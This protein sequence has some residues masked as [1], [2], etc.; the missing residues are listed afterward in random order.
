[1]EEWTQFVY[2]RVSTTFLHKTIGCFGGLLIG[3]LMVFLFRLGSPTLSSFVGCVDDNRRETIFDFCL[4]NHMFAHCPNS[5]NWLLLFGCFLIQIDYRRVWFTLSARIRYHV[6]IWD[7]FVLSIFTNLWI[8]FYETNDCCVVC[9]VP[10]KYRN[11]ISFRGH[12]L[13]AVVW[14]W[15]EK[16]CLKQNELKTVIFCAFQFSKIF[17]KRRKKSPFFSNDFMW[18]WLR[19][20][21]CI[22]GCECGLIWIVR[23]VTF[24][25][26]FIP[27]VKL[28]FCWVMPFAIPFFFLL[29]KIAIRHTI[30]HSIRIRFFLTTFFF[31]CI[32]V[33]VFSS[34][35][36]V[37]S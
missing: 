3:I 20:Y 32:F 6:V 4:L 35:C 16:S 10:T 7:S 14:K 9:S 37:R 22:A 33:C 36:I 26:T 27:L 12:K 31:C 30:Q 34:L 17:D 11:G 5:W 18:T 23:C 21:D 2:C 25:S 28:P 15:N 8:Y 24:V 1:M 19:P 29:Y 13:Y